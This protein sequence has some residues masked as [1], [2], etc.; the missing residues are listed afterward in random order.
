MRREQATTEM[1]LWVVKISE[2]TIKKAYLDE[3]AWKEA[4]AW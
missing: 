1:K 2:S 4:V 3:E